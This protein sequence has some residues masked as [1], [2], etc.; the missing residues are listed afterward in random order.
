VFH[1]N[2]ERV[3]LRFRRRGKG[4]STMDD[5]PRTKD[6]GRERIDDRR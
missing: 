5:G 3:Q 2:G 4:A 6:E 1:D